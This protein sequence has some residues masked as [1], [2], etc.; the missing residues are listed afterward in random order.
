MEPSANGSNGRGT[1]GRFAAGNAGGPGNPHAARVAQLRATLLAAVTDDDIR[2]IVATL[3]AQA[4]GGDLA[5]IRELLDRLLGK[6]LAGVAVTM[7]LEAPQD[8]DATRQRLAAIAARIEML[9][10]PAYLDYVR[11]AA[12]R[13]DGDAERQVA[14]DDEASTNF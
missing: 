13:E 11:K 9:N 2:A 8:L 12:M 7:E 3:V 10:E 1:G 4:K 5:A 14:S 6:P